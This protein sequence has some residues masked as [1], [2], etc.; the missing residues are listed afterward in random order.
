MDYRNYGG[1]YYVRLDRNDEVIAS[2]REVCERE[3]VRSATF[4]GVGGC[5]AAE[6][7][8]FDPEAGSF[9]TERY[10]G[11]LEL[12]SITGNVISCDDGSL[13]H[14]AHALFAYQDA[15]EQ[16]IAAGHL[17]SSTV[18]YTAEIELRPVAGGVIGA[19][20]NAETGTNFWKFES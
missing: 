20:R 12:V 18:R 3:G 6:I 16:R 2:I 10:E 13:S 14:H 8:V 1:C 17:K 11:L 9:R 5:D 19:E 7:Q 4:S 15:G